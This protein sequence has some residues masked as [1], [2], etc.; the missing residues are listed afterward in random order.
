[1]EDKRSHVCANVIKKSQV[2]H[3]GLYPG[4]RQGA[5]MYGPSEKPS[6]TEEEK[7]DT[8]RLGLRVF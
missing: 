8:K 4:D 6:I 1:M 2:Y 7:S 3:F 5:Q